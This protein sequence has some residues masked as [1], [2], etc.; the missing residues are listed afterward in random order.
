MSDLERERE[1]MMA[2]EA[3]DLPFGRKPG[4]NSG[5]GWGLLVAGIVLALAIP[6]FYVAFGLAGAVIASDLAPIFLTLLALVVAAVVVSGL[7]AYSKIRRARATGALTRDDVGNTISNT[8]GE[9]LSME[10]R[11]TVSSIMKRDP[12]ICGSLDSIYD[13]AKNMYSLNIGFVVVLDSQDKPI[14]VVTD[15]DLVCGGIANDVDMKST[16][17]TTVMESN[18]KFVRPTDTI[19]DCLTLMQNEGIRRVP[20]LEGDKF[21]GIVS[22][23][24]LIMS[25]RCS[26]EDIALILRRQLSEPNAEHDVSA[27][28]KNEH[29]AA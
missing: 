26:L 17:V 22:I 23:D 19:A 3:D 27:E 5:R 15:R 13:C 18:F 14:G 28:A 9:Q 20:V 21:V 24:D 16:P 7:Y 29:R 12:M 8:Q 1:R 2:N 11:D 25:R 4:E 6:L 10:N